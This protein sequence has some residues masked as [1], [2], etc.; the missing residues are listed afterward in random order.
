MACSALA[1]TPGLRAPLA[2]PA[3]AKVARRVTTQATAAPQ[4]AAKSRR[5]ALLKG[6]ALAAFTVASPALA[7]SETPKGLPEV[8]A[9]LVDF[10]RHVIDTH[11]EP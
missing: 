4:Q 9:C 3:A 6:A 8:R 2:R 11:L 1:S 5:D 7:D 10:A